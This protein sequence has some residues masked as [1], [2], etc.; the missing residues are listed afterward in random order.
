MPV[1][2]SIYSVL[3]GDAYWNNPEKFN[4]DRFFDEKGQLFVPDAWIPFGFGK[5]EIFFQVSL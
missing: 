2:M 5:H 4:P 3:M 1:Q